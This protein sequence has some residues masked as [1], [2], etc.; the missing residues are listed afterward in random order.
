MPLIRYAIGDIGVKTNRLCSCGRKFP[1]IERIIG[2]T[3]EK[4]FLADD[5]EV[6]ATTVISQITKI[7]DGISEYQAIQKKKGALE[8]L[9]I[10]DEKFNYQEE[11][12]LENKLLDAFS[13][14]EVN[15]IRVKEI[16]KTKAGKHMFFVSKVA[17]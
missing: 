11:K 8:V 4:L 7:S 10:A 2:R 1:M 12:E 14:E 6:F 5:K 16:P 13:L 17:K 15:I 3:S 9:V